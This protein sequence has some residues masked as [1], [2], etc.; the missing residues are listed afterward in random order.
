[1]GNLSALA[2]ATYTAA[3]GWVFLAFLTP[4]MPTNPAVILVPLVIGFVGCQ[5]DSIFGA[6]LET[7]GWLT[8]KTN[9]LLTVSIGAIL[10]WFVIH[11]NA[12]DWL[13]GLL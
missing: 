8:K 11:S 7:R 5:I 4:T 6:T 2:A 1:M 12:Y 3:V 9:N 13:M 10:A